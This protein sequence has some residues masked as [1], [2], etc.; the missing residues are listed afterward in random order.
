MRIGLGI[1]THQLIPGK[2]IKLGGVSIPSNVSIKA[3]SDGDIIYHAIADSILGAIG[4][5]DIGDHFPDTDSKNKDLDSRVIVMLAIKK[6]LSM[7]LILNNLDI[8]LLLEL[9]KISDYK[10]EIKKNLIKIFSEA[11]KDNY[12]ENMFNIKA[13]TSESLGFI[14]K[15]QGVTCYCIAS[16]KNL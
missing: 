6:A 3:H 11:T 12:A 5:G 4:A 15:G 14:G 13:S 7:K 9:P 1:D 8:T 2:L 10:N 16:L